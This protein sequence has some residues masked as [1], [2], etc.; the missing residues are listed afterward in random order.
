M[1]GAATFATRFSTVWQELAPTLALYVK[2]SNR[3]LATRVPPPMKMVVDPRR[4]GFLSELGFLYAAFA[5]DP[6]RYGFDETRVLTEAKTRISRHSLDVDV[7]SPVAE[8]KT[9]VTELSRRM[10]SYVRQAAE[11]GRIV[12]EPE[13][14][15]CGFVDASRGDVLAGSTL[16]EF[17]NVDRASEVPTGGNV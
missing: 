6:L 9:Y 7:S 13:F 2:T 10:A 15:G 4:Q 17:K 16:V 11:S 5:F 14:Q 12:F 8:E 1:I 3:A